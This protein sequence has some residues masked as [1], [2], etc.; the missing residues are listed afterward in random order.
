MATTGL[1]AKWPLLL[2]FG[3]GVAAIRIYDSVQTAYWQDPG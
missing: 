1:T 3:L 2:A